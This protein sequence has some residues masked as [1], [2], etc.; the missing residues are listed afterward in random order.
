M[1]PKLIKSITKEVYRRFPDL[2]GSQPKVRPQPAPQAK[3]MPA[4]P[5]YLLTYKGKAT[6]A[7]G[8]IIHRIVRVITDA[9]GNILK[10]TTSR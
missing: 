8:Q 4:A 1:E 10:I 2:Q 9:A 6:S 5:K 7:N 3:S